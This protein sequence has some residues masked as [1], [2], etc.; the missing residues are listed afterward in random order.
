MGICLLCIETVL[1]CVRESITGLGRECFV[2][3]LATLPNLSVQP[4]TRLFCIGKTW[5][6]Q[7]E[8]LRC[9]RQ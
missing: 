2:T 8:A 7:Q 1:C 4:I 9:F 3:S 6:F 5:I